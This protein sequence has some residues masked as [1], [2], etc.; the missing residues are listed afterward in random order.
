MIEVSEASVSE[1]SKI[2]LTSISFSFKLQASIFTDSPG[3]KFVRLFFFRFSLNFFLP[4]DLS[5]LLEQ[6][7]EISVKLLGES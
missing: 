3:H 4:V 7:F 6:K 1:L 2:H 5:F